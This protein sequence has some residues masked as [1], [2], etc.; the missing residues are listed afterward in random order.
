[1]DIL[2]CFTEFASM[3]NSPTYSR[4]Y[5]GPVHDTA[6]GVIHLLP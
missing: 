5:C 6:A 1:M 4:E 2:T 3:M